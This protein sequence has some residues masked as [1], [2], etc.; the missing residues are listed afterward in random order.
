MNSLI[1]RSTVLVAVAIGSLLAATPA[2][3]Q[4]DERAI[5]AAVTKFLDG[6]RT[7]DTSPRETAGGRD[8]RA[9]VARSP[10]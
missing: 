1:S 6:I 4:S 3:A 7:R 2:R 10:T 9:E 5:V 8:R